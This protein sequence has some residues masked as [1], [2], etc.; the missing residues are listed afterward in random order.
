MEFFSLH[1]FSGPKQT[2]RRRSLSA[3]FVVIG[4]F[5][6]L[7]TMLL[8]CIVINQAHVASHGE[9]ETL[10]QKARESFIESFAR[11][12]WKRMHKP[13]TEIMSKKC[14]NM[15]QKSNAINRWSTS[16]SRIPKT[17]FEFDFLF[18]DI[19][20]DNKRVYEERIAQKEETWTTEKINWRWKH[21]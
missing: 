2:T 10:F 9:N 17:T 14:R 15:F 8:W 16:T 21:D 11:F 5:I 7:E 6:I 3:L 19:I 1:R 4:C 12:V 18:S 13:T 20:S